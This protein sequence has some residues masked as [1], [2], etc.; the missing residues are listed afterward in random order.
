MKEMSRWA[1]EDWRLL[2]CPCGNCMAISWLIPPTSTLV[3]IFWL[4]CGPQFRTSIW[5]C[6]NIVRTQLMSSQTYA[7]SG[8][9][10]LPIIAAGTH[11]R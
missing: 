11:G 1:A 4:D 3:W 8:Y 5:N 6:A 9:A 7:V 2:A 10:T